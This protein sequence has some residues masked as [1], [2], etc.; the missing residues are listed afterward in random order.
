MKI[1][2]QT[3]LIS[4]IMLTIFLLGVVV[5]AQKGGPS[6]QKT[7]VE[8]YP[9]NTGKCDAKQ[10]TAE[11]IKKRPKGRGRCKDIGKGD[12]QCRCYYQCRR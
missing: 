2:F 12:W 11:C 9:N 8:A 3:S 5:S 4:F 10:C 6:T 7:C 1:S